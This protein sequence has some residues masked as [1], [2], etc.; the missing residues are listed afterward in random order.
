MR[1]MPDVM[2]VYY[3][4]RSLWKWLRMSPSTVW[5]RSERRRHKS[6][7]H[8]FFRHETPTRPR[9]LWLHSG[10]MVAL[11]CRWCWKSTGRSGHQ[12]QRGQLAIFGHSKIYSLEDDS[13]QRT[14]TKLRFIFAP[15]LSRCCTRLPWCVWT[16]YR[17]WFKACNDCSMNRCIDSTKKLQWS[18]LPFWFLPWVCPR[19]RMD[20]WNSDCTAFGAWSLLIDDGILIACQLVMVW[21]LALGVMWHI[22]QVCSSV[23]SVLQTQLFWG[24][25]STLPACFSG[26]L[27]ATLRHEFI[28]AAEAEKRV[29][30]IC[31]NAFSAAVS[32]RGKFE[33]DQLKLDRQPQHATKSQW[34]VFSNPL[35]MSGS[36]ACRRGLE[37]SCIYEKKMCE[38]TSCLAKKWNES[39][40]NPPKTRSG[41][42]WWM[43]QLYLSIVYV[44]KRGVHVLQVHM[45]V[46][47]PSQPAPMTPHQA[48]MCLMRSLVPRTFFFFE[49]W[50]RFQTAYGLLQWLYFC[51][52]H[53]K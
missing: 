18:R 8:I 34:R 48:K 38:H 3:M 22:S 14:S 46:L 43:T 4:S 10:Y 33:S 36:P 41:C 52:V 49:N 32:F 26:A 23:H 24:H 29:E 15:G 50:T 9:P 17:S 12:V 35:S 20:R 39:F 30:M 1:H 40:L 19:I 11:K 44:L 27:S 28:K 2:R 42:W 6:S 5:G 13:T 21:S 53:R 7:K 45:C 47:M 31:L 16:W 25:Y 37:T 51:A